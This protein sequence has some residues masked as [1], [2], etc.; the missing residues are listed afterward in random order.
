MMMNIELKENINRKIDL[1][2]SCT[3]KKNLI[4]Q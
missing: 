2:A 3:L 1:L 4:I